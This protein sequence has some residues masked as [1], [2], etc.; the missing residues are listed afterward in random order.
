MLLEFINSS[1]NGSAEKIARTMQGQLLVR[2]STA[3]V[4]SNGLSTIQSQEGLREV[5]N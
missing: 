3:A 1:I 5:N 4:N 2:A